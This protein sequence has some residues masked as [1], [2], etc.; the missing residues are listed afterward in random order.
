MKTSRAGE[1]GRSRWPRKITRSALLADIERARLHGVDVEQGGRVAGQRMELL[2]GVWPHDER[3]PADDDRKA[4][5]DGEHAADQHHRRHPDREHRRHLGIG[6]QPGERHQHRHV[7]RGRDQ[8]LE[9]DE[10]L[11]PDQLGDQAGRQQPVHRVGEEAGGRI[12]AEQGNEDAQDESERPAEFPQQVTADDQ[13]RVPR[14]IRSTRRS[15]G[16]LRQSRT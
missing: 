15:C 6:I 3:Q 8:H 1:P 16:R 11:Q 5:R 9:R 4:A 12:A 14:K 7:E 2:I 13:D 10:Y